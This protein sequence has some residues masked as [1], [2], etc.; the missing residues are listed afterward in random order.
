MWRDVFDEVGVVY[1]FE[2]EPPTL[3]HAGLPLVLGFAVLLGAKRRMMQ[4][5]KEKPRLFVKGLADTGRDITERF[6]GGLG[7]YELH[8]AGLAFRLAT[9]SSLM[10]ASIEARS[11]ERRVGKECR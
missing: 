3:I 8:R 6:K 7:V 1:Y 4:V 11:E 2:I 5:L 9:R 10:F